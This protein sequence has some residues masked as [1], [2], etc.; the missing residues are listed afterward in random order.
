MTPEWLAALVALV[1][2]PAALWQ[3]LQAQRWKRAEWVAQEVKE[4]LQDPGVASALLM[5][6]WKARALPLLLPGL[7]TEK[8]FDYEEEMLIHALTSHSSHAKRPYTHAEVSI[9]D[10][11]DRLLGGLERFQN[12]IDVG[13]ITRREVA[14]YLQYWIEVIGDPD[15][16]Q[17]GEAARQRLWGYIRDYGY[18][19]VERLLLGFGYAIRPQGKAA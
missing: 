1:G 11:F 14:P 18:D 6:D 7:E 13:L 5:L 17:K 15:N 12:F 2:V 4:F 3:Y 19:G 16:T 9:R 8:Q 10:S